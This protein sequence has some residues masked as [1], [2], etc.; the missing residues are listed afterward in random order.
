MSETHRKRQR[1]LARSAGL[2][3]EGLPLLVARRL[4]LFTLDQLD[5][6]TA[7]YGLDIT[8]RPIA[9]PED[10]HFTTSEEECIR[11]SIGQVLVEIWQQDQLPAPDDVRAQL[12][13]EYCTV[14][15]V[16]RA[17]ES[18]HL[19]WLQIKQMVRVLDRSY[20]AETGE[21]PPAGI[22]VG[23]VMQKTAAELHRMGGIG[24]H[25]LFLIKI[26]LKVEG[27]CLKEE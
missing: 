9:N 10:R 6:F 18:S 13:R 22:T 7:F 17:L 5:L 1:N 27:L 25:R 14:R 15:R 12:F 20:L 26:L 16:Y 19:E 8:G 24:G 2:G 11:T 23:A 3:V 21:E 4:D